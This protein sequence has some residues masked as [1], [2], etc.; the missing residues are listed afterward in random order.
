VTLEPT[1]DA[2]VTSVLDKLADSGAPILELHRGDLDS[3]IWDQAR[4][5]L[6]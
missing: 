5:N 4:R 3:P 2:F 6:P 1:G